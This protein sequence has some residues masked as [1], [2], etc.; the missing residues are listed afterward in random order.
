MR[1]L[2]PVHSVGM[3]SKIPVK[4]L[5]TLMGRAILALV[6]CGCLSLVRA[7]DAKSRAALAVLKAECFSCH[8]DAKQKGGLSLASRDA[9]LKGGDEGPAAHLGRDWRKSPMLALIQPGAD[10]HMPPRKQL[11]SDQIRSLT[12]WVRSGLAWDQSVIDNEEAPRPVSVVASIPRSTRSRPSH[13]LPTPAASP[14]L[15]A[16]G[17]RSLTSPRPPLGNSPSSRPMLIP[18]NPSHGVMTANAS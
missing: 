10:P 2:S 1:D 4:L 18:S 14:S 7:A 3:V 15:V 16:I 17:S 12:D 6:M 5:H 13:S 9:L 11:D 8:G